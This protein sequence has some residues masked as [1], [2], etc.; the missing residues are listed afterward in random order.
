MEL[1]HIRG[2]DFESLFYFHAS[3]HVKAT[4]CFALQRYESKLMPLLRSKLPKENNFP[5]S[6]TNLVTLAASNV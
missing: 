2:R 3:L 4:E 5:M 1:F 6:E